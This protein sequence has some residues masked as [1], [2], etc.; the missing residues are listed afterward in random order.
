[1]S[2]SVYLDEPV[3]NYRESYNLFRHLT[4]KNLIWQT[5]HY[6]QPLSGTAPESIPSQLG[7][8]QSLWVDCPQF[9]V[10]TEISSPLKVRHSRM[11]VAGIQA[12]S[13]LDPDKDIRG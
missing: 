8:F 2:W 5:L 11:F 3:H 9:A 7:S 12:N 1:M 13:G 10:H 6:C 4:T